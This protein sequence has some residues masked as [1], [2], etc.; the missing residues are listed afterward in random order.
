MEEDEFYDDDF[1]NEDF[2]TWRTV[3]PEKFMAENWLSF[4]ALSMK[5]KR[6]KDGDMAAW[7]ARIDEIFHDS[8]LLESCRKEHLS[9]AQKRKQK[10]LLKEIKRHGL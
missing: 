4:G 5:N 1:F 9:F 2:P 6:F 10:A 8:D 7:A 3:S